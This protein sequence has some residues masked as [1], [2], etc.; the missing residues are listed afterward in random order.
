MLQL[1]APIRISPKPNFEAPFHI[2][3]VVCGHE[4]T[5]KKYRAG[6][7][8]CGGTLDFSYPGESQTWAGNCRSMWRYR[9]RL[10]VAPDAA[11]VSLD[12]GGTPASSFSSKTRR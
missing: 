7:P 11:I 6:C 2:R 1:K 10:P 5:G 9:Q 4:I 12:E 8:S 3:C